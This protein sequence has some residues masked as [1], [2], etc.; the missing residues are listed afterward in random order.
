AADAIRDQF[1][2]SVSEMLSGAKEYADTA[3]KHRHADVLCL[4]RSAVGLEAEDRVKRMGAP[5][6]VLTS[7]PYPGVHVLYHRWQVMGRRETP[8]P[9]WIVGTLDWAGASFYTFGDRKQKDLRRYYEQASQ[10]FSSSAN[11]MPGGN[12]TR[13]LAYASGAVGFL[14]YAVGFIAS[15]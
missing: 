6:L 4:H 14:A 8:A 3:R 11:V 15:F 5:R 9:F 12:A 2:V 7:P 1:L 10:A 13:Q